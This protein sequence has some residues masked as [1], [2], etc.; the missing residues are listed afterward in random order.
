MLDSEQPQGSSKRT[1]VVSLKLTCLN[2]NILF[3]DSNIN[4]FITIE[5]LNTSS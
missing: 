4:D 1:F 5:I 2:T 3:S